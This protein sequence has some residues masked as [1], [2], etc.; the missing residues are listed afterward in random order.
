MKYRLLILT[1]LLIVT[2]S[3][4]S[5]AKTIDWTYGQLAPAQ[6]DKSTPWQDTEWQDER[7]DEAALGVKAMWNNRKG[8]RIQMRRMFDPHGR[9]LVSLRYDVNKQSTMLN[10]KPGVSELIERGLVPG[11]IEGYSAEQVSSLFS[12]T[13]VRF[14]GV[15]VT[16]DALTYTASCEKGDLLPAMEL[17]RAY[18]LASGWR[19]EAE[20]AVKREWFEDIRRR[21]SNIDDQVELKMAIALAGSYNWKRPATLEEARAVSFHDADSWLGKALKDAKLTVSIAGDTPDDAMD[22]AVRCFGP[23]HVPTH[24]MMA[25]IDDAR[26][27]LLTTKRF[28]PGI[29]RVT[30]MGSSPRVVVNIAWPTGD[31]YDIHRTRNLDLVARCLNDYLGAAIRKTYGN[32]SSVAVWCTASET[33]RNNGQ[34]HVLAKVMS[35]NGDQVL[36]DIKKMV[37][38]FARQHVDAKLLASEKASVLKSA[39]RDRNNAE[40]WMQTVM[41]YLCWQPFRT[42]WLKD[43]DVN[44]RSAGA[45]DIHKL[46]QRYLDLSKSYAVVGVCYR[47]VRTS[48]R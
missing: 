4:G 9:V 28:K 21:Q 22:D 29:T 37:G 3:S 15:K 40:W 17:L 45:S 18:S 16:D 26:N 42:H 43:M 30:A 1:T 12:Q 39:G 11:G 25:S 44:Y 13:S 48:R 32:Q 47:A 31:I 10:R 6:T 24:F 23:Y 46:A 33:I 38:D 5:V 2:L 36:R 8:L 34:I 20:K 27:S 35:T 14:L 19:P 7:Q 41:P